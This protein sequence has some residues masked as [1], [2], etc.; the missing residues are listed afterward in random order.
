MKKY[1]LQSLPRGEQLITPK[2]RHTVNKNFMSTQI[3]RFSQMPLHKMPNSKI[4]KII[5]V[6]L[7]F[8]QST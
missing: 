7:F 8:Y 6:N 5:Q 4:L 1:F 2:T 3:E